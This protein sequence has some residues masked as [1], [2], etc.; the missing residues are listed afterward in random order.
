MLRQRGFPAAYYVFL[1]LGEWKR[2][3]R[4]P[5]ARNKEREK[6][7]SLNIEIRFPQSNA[8]VVD[9]VGGI[10]PADAHSGYLRRSAAVLR[11][12]DFDVLI[13]NLPQQAVQLLFVLPIPVEHQWDDG[14][15]QQQRPGHD[16]QYFRRV[17]WKG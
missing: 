3:G 6:N 15:H 4:V 14:Q 11:V 12:V 16:R 9:G 5:K 2:K 17:S 10:F 8:I 7:V 13:V 1:P